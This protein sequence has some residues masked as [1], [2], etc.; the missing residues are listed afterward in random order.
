[1]RSTCKH[2]LNTSQTL[3]ISNAVRGSECTGISLLFT[4]TGF[5]SSPGR[6][7]ARTLI[8]FIS[9]KRNTIGNDEE[10]EQTSLEE[11]VDHREKSFP[12][13]NHS[14]ITFYTS[15]EYW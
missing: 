6:N 3:P 1:M 7:S 9:R 12:L 5:N 14:G 4:L 11:P 8:R 2:I 13:S 10:K 15:A